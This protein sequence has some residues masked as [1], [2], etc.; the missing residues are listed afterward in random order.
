MWNIFTST[1]TYTSTG[2]T[3]LRATTLVELP[4][5]LTRVATRVSLSREL[6]MAKGSSQGVLFVSGVGEDDRIWHSCRDVF[7]HGARAEE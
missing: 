4:L 2:G 3:I 1:V 7:H 5:A 6:N